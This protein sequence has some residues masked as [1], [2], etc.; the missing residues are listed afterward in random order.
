M[1][2]GNL[3]LNVL[4]CGEFTNPDNLIKAVTLLSQ[5]SSGTPTTVDATTIPSALAVGRE[6]AFS[7]LLAASHQANAHLSRVDGV[8]AVTRMKTIMSYLVIYF[9]LEYA[10]V[11]K[12]KVDYPDKTDQWVNL[13]KYRL[14]AEM[15]NADSPSSG[16]NINAATMRSHSKY[17]KVFGNTANNLE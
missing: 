3:A 16:S 6:N 2:S 17:G 11:Q 14:F 10:V 1:S 8:I 15:L 5:I 12:L 7:G 4:L 9:T 13:A